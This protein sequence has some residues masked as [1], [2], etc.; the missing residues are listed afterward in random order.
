MHEVKIEK[1]EGPLGLLLKI[2]EKEEMDITEIS[3]AGIADEFVNYIRSS[4]AN[5]IDPEEMA[6]FLVIAAKLLLIKSKA[7]LPYL[8]PEE[9]EDIE[10]L[11]QQLKMYKEFVEAATKIEKMLGKKKFMF[12]REFNRKVVLANAETF[13]PPKKLV[14]ADMAVVFEGLLVR[15]Q[16]AEKMEK[17]TIE[18]EINIEEKIFTIK[19][20]LIKRIKV[21]FNKVMAQAKN[22]TEII[23]SFLA[24]LEMMRQREVH[25]TQDEMFGDIIINKK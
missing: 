7:L 23:V 6:D 12:A 9:E 18:E 14:A 19:E 3:L 24:M 10:E 16:P 4:D 5:E 25:L 1:F 20:L 11:E 13:S 8:L 21:S 17:G 2:I 22:K 15:L